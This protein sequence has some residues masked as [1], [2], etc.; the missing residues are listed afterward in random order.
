MNTLNTSYDVVELVPNGADVDVTNENVEEFLEHLLRH[1][2]LDRFNLQLSFFLKGFDEVMPHTLISVF[3]ARELELM[4]CGRPTIDVDDWKRFT[5]YR[6]RFKAPKETHKVVKWFWE[7]VE[8]MDQSTRGQLL[9]F[10]TGSEK[11]PVQGFEGLQGDD[12]AM[13]HFSI[14]STTMDSSVF[15][16]AHTCFNRLEL[17]LYRSKEDM[18]KFMTEAIAMRDGF[19]ME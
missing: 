17:P 13:M 14:E 15:P 12:G 16:R 19:N 3:T 1:I 9:Q 10:A 11:V 5:T 6:G 2:A 7:I 4:L 18:M 8:E